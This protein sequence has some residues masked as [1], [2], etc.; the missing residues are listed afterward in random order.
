MRIDEITRESIPGVSEVIGSTHELFTFK[1]EDDEYFLKFSRPELFDAVDP[2][3]QVLVEYLAYRI[4]GLFPGVSVP[5]KIH[6]VTD[7][8]DKR[9]GLAT[10]RVSG[11]PSWSVEPGE[12]GQMMSAGVFVDIFLAN[13]D[14]IGMSEDNVLVSGDTA[15]R[16]DP[17]GALTFRARGGRKGERFSDTPGELETMLDPSRGAGMVFS[18]SHLKKAAE[19]FSRV[20]WSQIQQEIRSTHRDVLGELRGSFPGLQKEWTK[21]V[22]HISGTLKKR[23]RGVMVHVRGLLA[24]VL[25]QTLLRVVLLQ[26]VRYGTICEQYLV[27]KSPW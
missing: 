17:G 10:R 26:E 13:W 1:L 27:G 2:S 5:S 14:V 15:T 6:L 19:T 16:I 11:E 22:N 7:T 9:V 4:Y 25:V 24:E 3:L 8:S 18:K 12:L 20:G 23:H 21:E